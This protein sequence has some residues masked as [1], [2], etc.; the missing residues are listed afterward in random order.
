MRYFILFLSV[1][2]YQELLAQIYV[3]RDLHVF[4]KC[5]SSIQLTFLPKTSFS[6]EVNKNISS[7]YSNFQW[8]IRFSGA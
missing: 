6:S 8:D 7:K 4:E 1:I 3:N 2:S 5:D